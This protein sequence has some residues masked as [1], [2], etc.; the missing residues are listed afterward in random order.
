VTTSAG[1]I[2]ELV[3]HGVNGLVCEPGDDA[4]IAAHL[5]A[6]LDDAALRGRIAAA[7]R[8]TVEEAYDVDAAARALDG[9]FAGAGA[10]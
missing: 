4:A 8:R 6:V 5:R 9:I 2:T 7:G 1:G 10:S 3:Q